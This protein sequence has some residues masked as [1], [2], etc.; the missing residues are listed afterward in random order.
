MQRGKVNSDVEKD[1]ERADVRFR[2]LYLDPQRRSVGEIKR[3]MGSEGFGGGLIERVVRRTLS[4]RIPSE[5]RVIGNAA[6]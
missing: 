2:E 3:Q 1:V 5:L 4:A 6:R